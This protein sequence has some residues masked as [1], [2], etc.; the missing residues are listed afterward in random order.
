MGGTPNFLGSGAWKL[1]EYASRKST[2]ETFSPVLKA[3]SLIGSAR[4][5]V[6]IILLGNGKYS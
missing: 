5:T 1:L 2:R 6:S 4:M 3:L